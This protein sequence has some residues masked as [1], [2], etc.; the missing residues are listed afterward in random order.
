MDE[1]S[2]VLLPA[3]SDRGL[4]ILKR[5]DPVEALLVS[6]TL[7]SVLHAPRNLVT[8]ACGLI[9]EKARTRETSAGR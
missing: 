7:M 6:L 9:F 2:E 3:I 4:A 8:S 5:P 1:V